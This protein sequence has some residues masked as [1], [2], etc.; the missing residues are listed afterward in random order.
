MEEMG[1]ILLKAMKGVPMEKI[2]GSCGGSKLRKMGGDEGEWG[3][4]GDPK[5]DR[6]RGREEG[7]GSLTKVLSLY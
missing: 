1:G 6:G 3:S 7:F 2:G 5:E 4:R